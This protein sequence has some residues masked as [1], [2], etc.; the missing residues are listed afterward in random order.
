MIFFPLNPL[1]QSNQEMIKCAIFGKVFK[2]GDMA[3]YFFPTAQ[4]DLEKIRRHYHD[5]MYHGKKTKFL[6]IFYAFRYHRMYRVS[7]Q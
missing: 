4:N 5:D 7:P 1:V 3:S 6:K 2:N